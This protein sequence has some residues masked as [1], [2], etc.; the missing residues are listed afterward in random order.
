MFNYLI[1][2]YLGCHY[3]NKKKMNKGDI[4][5]SWNADAI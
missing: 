1:D 3:K 4:I 2:F 5:W